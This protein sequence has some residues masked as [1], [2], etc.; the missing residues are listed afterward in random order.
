MD[1][2]QKHHVSEGSQTQK[3]KLYDYLYMKVIESEELYT[4]T[5]D[6]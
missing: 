1:K 4:Q 3:T 5:A 2:S 6:Q